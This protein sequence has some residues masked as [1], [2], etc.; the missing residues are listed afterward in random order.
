[1]ANKWNFTRC[2]VGMLVGGVEK[3]KDC[4]VCRSS[5]CNHEQ[6]KTWKNWQRRSTISSEITLE[7]FTQ[8]FNAQLQVLREIQLNETRPF[9][10]QEG[11]SALFTVE[12][13]WA[14]WSLRNWLQKVFCS[15]FK[16]SICSVK[17]RSHLATSV[18]SHS[19]IK[20]LWTCSTGSQTSPCKTQNIRIKDSFYPF[21]SCTMSFKEKKKNPFLESQKKKKRGRVEFTPLRDLIAHHGPTRPNPAPPWIA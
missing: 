6:D 19:I 11:K 5:F 1:M 14:T 17:L 13:T 9:C 3:I 20:H 16:T 21:R 4:C 10:L 2:E 18:S 7:E 15:P 12:V 8:D